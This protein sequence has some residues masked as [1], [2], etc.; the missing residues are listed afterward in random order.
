MSHSLPRG[1]VTVTFRMDRPLP[2][3]PVKCQPRPSRA[4]DWTHP[5]CWLR[6]CPL[7]GC[8]L[9]PGCG[10]LVEPLPHSGPARRGS[11]QLPGAPRAPEVS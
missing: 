8:V 9:T 7:G 5:G 11:R 3:S 6:Q 10:V 2:F 4:Q 1:R